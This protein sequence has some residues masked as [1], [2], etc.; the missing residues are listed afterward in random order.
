M[1]AQGYQLLEANAP[2]QTV[3]KAARG[4]CKQGNEFMDA[5]KR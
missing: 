2:G 3:Y 5:V 1:E 4:I